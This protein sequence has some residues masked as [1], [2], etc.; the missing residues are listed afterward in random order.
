M[1]I[2]V[3][4]EQ[5]KGR[6]AAVSWEVLGKARELAAALDG[7]LA[8]VVIGDGVEALAQ[9]AISY[10]ADI[11]HL[12]EDASLAG[13]RLDPYAAVIEALIDEHHPSILLLGATA[14]GRDLAAVVACD[15]NAGLAADCSD[16]SIEAGKL[17]AVRPVFSGNMLTTIE[18][19]SD[20]QVASVRARSFPLQE[21]DAG[22]PGEIKRSGAVMAEAEI[23]SQVISF[24]EASAGEISLADAGVIVSGGRGVSKDPAAG[25]AA[26]K[27]LADQLGGAMGASRAAVDAGYIPYKHQVGQTGKTVRPDLYIAAGISG[28]IQHLAGMNSSKIIVAINKDPDA[29]IFNVANYGVVGDLFEVV[30]ALTAAFEERMG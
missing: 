18:F 29:P 22:R 6:A 5:F 19:S 10:G 25:F 16:L 3:Y 24:E 11:V 4:I 13:F 8:A 20:L 7:P 15:L 21:A 23:G 9:E 12:V 30:P 26:V 17:A 28:A 27:A 14:R 1:S 2:L